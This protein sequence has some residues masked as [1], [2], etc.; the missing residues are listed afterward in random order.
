MSPNK[1][2]WLLVLFYLLKLKDNFNLYGVRMSFVF[3]KNF[4]NRHGLNFN[5]INAKEIPIKLYQS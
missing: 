1:S 5:K 3:V 2:K 4:I